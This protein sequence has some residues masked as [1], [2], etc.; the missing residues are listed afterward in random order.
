MTSATHPS[1]RASGSRLWRPSW[2]LL[3]AEAG[4]LVAGELGEPWLVAQGRQILIVTREARDLGHQLY[5][6]T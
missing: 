2:D 1:L 3:P 6:A 4:R 5:G